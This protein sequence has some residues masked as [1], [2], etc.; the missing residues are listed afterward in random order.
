MESLKHRRQSTHAKSLREFAGRIVYAVRHAKSFN[1]NLNHRQTWP[2]F[3]NRLLDRFILTPRS[4]YSE[5]P[6]CRIGFDLGIS[7]CPGRAE[8]A[9]GNPSVSKPAETAFW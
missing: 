6:I 8:Q 7:G 2:Y 5:N 3:A 9:M 1:A 4:P